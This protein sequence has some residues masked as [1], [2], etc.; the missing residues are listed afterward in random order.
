MLKQKGVVSVRFYSFSGLPWEIE[1][2]EK[3]TEGSTN[4]LVFL[5]RFELFTVASQGF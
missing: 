5:H 4:Y 2:R 1:V 3:W